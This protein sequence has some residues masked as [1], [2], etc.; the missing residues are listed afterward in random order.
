MSHITPL[1]QI[2][3]HTASEAS[4]TAWMRIVTILDASHEASAL[5]A[6]LEPYLELWPDRLRVLPE[7]WFEALLSDPSLGKARICRR[8]S[9]KRATLSEDLS[10]CLVD[11]SGLSTITQLEL[12]RCQFSTPAIEHLLHAPLWSNLTSLDLGGTYLDARG[13]AALA[14]STALSRLTSLKLGRCR[15]DHT[16]IEVLTQSTTLTQLKKLYLRQN[17]IGDR[18]LE[19]LAQWASLAQCE[20]LVVSSNQVGS[21]GLEALASHHVLCSLK[22]LDVSHNNITDTGLAALAQAPHLAS[23]EQLWLGHNQ[24]QGGI[25]ALTRGQAWPHLKALHLEASD[26]RGDDILALANACVLPAIE[27]LDV[28]DNPVGDEGA[29]VLAQPEAFPTL[30][31]LQLFNA[32]LTSAGLHHLVCAPRLTQLVCL[33]LAS[34][35]MD[36]TVIEALARRRDIGALREIYL[37]STQLEVCGLERLTQALW[38][39]QL[40]GVWL[41]GNPLGDVGA[42]LLAFADAPSLKTLRLN[43]CG[44][45]DDGARALSR[46]TGMRSL[47][48]LILDDNKVGSEG[49]V[50]LATST[51]CPS[52]RMLH[53]RGMRIDDRARAALQARQAREPDF[54]W[55]E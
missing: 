27:V 49:L 40:E 5:A 41:D 13:M 18:G 6:W 31:T 4:T 39:S 33:D 45:G 28:D 10:A 12:R 38:W 52:L 47:E 14:Q 23:L 54:S 11:A 16:L 42:L 37:S 1:Q 29:R 20:E 22:S 35:P 43:D 9:L 19:A 7:S 53:V 17:H 2:L 26:L 3:W 15:L 32:G 34:N 21:A 51:A 55:R 46:T 50:A 25:A 44:V 36:D 24:L 8:V 30:K 48:R